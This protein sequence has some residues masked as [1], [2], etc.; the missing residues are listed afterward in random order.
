VKVNRFVAL[1]AIAV[2]VVAALGLF[3]ACSFAQASQPVARQGAAKQA[4]AVQAATAVPTE[5]PGNTETNQQS[6]QTTGQTGGPETTEPAGAATEAEGAV[7]PTEAAGAG[8]ASR[9]AAEAAGGQDQQSPSFT[10]SITLTESATSANLSESAE[11]AALASQAKITTD[12]ANAA[13]LAANPGTTVVKTDL[14]NENGSLVY[15]VELSNGSDVK[16]DAGNAKILATDT[17]GEN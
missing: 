14:G 16:V 2:M 17:G 4:R 6:E 11:A 8:E 5:A 1:A 15:S 7:E 10:G 12:R 13:A 3:S 9:R